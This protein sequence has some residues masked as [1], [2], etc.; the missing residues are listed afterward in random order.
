MHVQVRSVLFAPDLLFIL[1]LFCIFTSKKLFKSYVRQIFFLFWFFF[2]YFHFKKIVP[3]D[4]VSVTI[5]I[6]IL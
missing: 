3:H 4:V 5:F 1:V 2:V 6:F